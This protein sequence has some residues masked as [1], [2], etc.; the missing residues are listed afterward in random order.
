M[1]N[2]VPNRQSV[3]TYFGLVVTFFLTYIG[4][5][6]KRSLFQLR[7]AECDLVRW[8]DAA[9]NAGMP[10]AEYV[11]QSIEARL[12]DREAD[13]LRARIARAV[14]ALSGENPA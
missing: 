14:A 12:A 6:K 8:R 11:R 5:M 4:G 3:N 2:V 9:D 13:M 7:V 1:N 10:L